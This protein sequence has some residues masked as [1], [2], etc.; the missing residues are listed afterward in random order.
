MHRSR[1]SVLVLRS[2]LVLLG[3]LLVC[4]AVMPRFLFSRNM[5]GVSNFG[6]HGETVVPYTLG[7][8]A[9]VWLLWRSATQL[10]T[11]CGAGGVVK[12]TRVV[13]VCLLANLITTYAYRSG[14]TWAAVHSWTATALA[15]A[16]FGGGLLLLRW[17]SGGLC[18]TAASG[19][20]VLGMAC[21]VLT[22]LG[23]LH[24]LF[25]AEVTTATGF[26]LAL[27]AAV[28]ALDSRERAT[29]GSGSPAAGD[30]RSEG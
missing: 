16:E 28:R 14:P 23:R 13:S 5:G 24:V 4:T 18:R 12:V 3:S 20:I 26:G 27:V 22:Y 1:A 15:V 30:D 6:T 10:R 7:T 29:W 17:V 11:T 2:Q 9:A 21:L 8:V 19:F 25:V